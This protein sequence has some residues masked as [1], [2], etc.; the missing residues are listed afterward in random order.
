MC[1]AHGPCLP[2]L[3]SWAFAKGL[4]LPTLP[5]L[6]PHLNLE[7]CSLAPRSWNLT[8]HFFSMTFK[9]R[10]DKWFIFHNIQGSER[11][12]AMSIYISFVFSNIQGYPSI[13]PL[14]F[15]HPRPEACF[16]TAL[17]SKDC[18]SHRQSLDSPL[19]CCFFINIQGSLE[20][21]PFFPSSRRD[22]F[23]ISLFSYACID[24]AATSALLLL[25]QV[26]VFS[27]TFKVQTGGPG[28][29]LPG[30]AFHLQQ[31]VGD[32]P[33]FPKVVILH[34]P[35]ERRVGMGGRDFRRALVGRR[36]LQGLP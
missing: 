21:S 14:P 30:L 11:I 22:V 6:I 25:R 7:T 36:T 27:Y 19:T 8:T 12:C 9:V 17:F 1:G 28:L 24:P 2:A 34:S 32:P 26:A 5:S 15:F 20:A 18:Y 31:Q 23:V 3:S 4:A 29:F 10:G 13:L 33:D 35:H 16:L